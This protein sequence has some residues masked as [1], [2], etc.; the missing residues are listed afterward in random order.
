[1]RQPGPGAIWVH[2]VSVG[3]A[4]ACAQLLPALRRRFPNEKIFV[5]T[6]TPT[7]QE[8][9]QQRLAKWADG[10]FYAPDPSSQLACAIAGNIGMNSGGAHCLE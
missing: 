4:L 10:F 1:M 7:G 3:E 6:G 8:Q 9:A 2:A 5:S